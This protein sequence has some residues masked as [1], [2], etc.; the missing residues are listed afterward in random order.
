MT[1]FFAIIFT[2]G[3]ATPTLAAV[4]VSIRDMMI[5]RTRLARRASRQR[6][7]ATVLIYHSDTD[8]TVRSVRQLRRIR[9]L[10]LSIVV[11]AP[12]HTSI[13]TQL[14]GVRIYHKQSPAPR[15]LTLAS[16]YPLIDP[17]LPLL[18]IDSGDIVP[19][20][21]IHGALREF[22]NR[23]SLSRI[24]LRRAPHIDVSFASVLTWL[25]AAL[26]H[27][28]STL[29]ARNYAAL[30]A[31]VWL[32]NGRLL[33]QTNAVQRTAYFSLL[34]ISVTAPA[35]IPESSAGALLGELL[36]VATAGYCY[37]V[38]LVAGTTLPIVMF[39]TLSAWWLVTL[40]SSGTAG[41][42]Q[43]TTVAAIIPLAGI[44]LPAWFLLVTTN[45]LQRRLWQ[46]LTR[47]RR[48]NAKHGVL[49]RL[50]HP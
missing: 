44:V 43:K 15:Q 37:V 39:W 7:A 50:G 48:Q 8:A 27:T 34:T 12:A 45:T 38:A 4:I 19:A 10:K 2:L 17:T 33:R 47:A 46:R 25:G 1:S 5:E 26:R 49:F 41:F 32:R 21:V 9:A 31:G 30:P 29:H 11:V 14:R 35:Q 36:V 16:A 3:V 42:R 6:T 28:L 18:V 13:T 22:R 40:V 24:I 23:P 20:P